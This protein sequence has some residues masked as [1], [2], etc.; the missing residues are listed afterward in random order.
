M[1]F[2][3]TLELFVKILSGLVLPVVILMWK[4]LNTRIDK[5]EKAAKERT[6]EIKR[7]IK[8]DLEKLDSATATE[9]K[10][11]KLRHDASLDKY[12]KGREE[13]LHRFYEKRIDDHK[14]NTA[15]FATNEA[16]IRDNAEIKGKLSD[17]FTA[18]GE[19]SKTLH[20]HIGNRGKS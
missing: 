2:I 17:I 15:T 20:T 7:E 14:Y 16:R 3:P 13:E 4:G 5:G 9:L 1:E 12:Y 18:L 6:D 10:D 8:E 11:L 19:F